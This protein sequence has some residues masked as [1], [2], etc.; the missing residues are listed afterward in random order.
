MQKV[1]RPLLLLDEVFA[2][3]SLLMEF[4]DGLQL[5]PEEVPVRHDPVVFLGLIALL[6]FDQGALDHNVEAKALAPSR[7]VEHR[8]QLHDR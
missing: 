8:P 5:G 4:H 2:V 7:L 3:A 6:V 1:V